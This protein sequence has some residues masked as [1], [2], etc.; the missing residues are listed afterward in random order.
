MEVIAEHPDDILA[1]GYFTNEDPST[2][3]LLADSTY[4]YEKMKIRSMYFH[5]LNSNIELILINLLLALTS[6]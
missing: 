4:K 6:S 3:K 2:A 1:Y 5:I